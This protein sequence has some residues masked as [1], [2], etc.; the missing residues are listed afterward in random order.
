MSTE[1]ELQVTTPTGEGASQ[2]GD[3]CIVI[4]LYRYLLLT[5][6]LSGLAQ[7]VELNRGHSGNQAIVSY[8]IGHFPRIYIRSSL[9]YNVSFESRRVLYFAS[10][11]F[12]PSS[13]QL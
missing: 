10:L 11:G 3:V 1:P 2:A 12:T 9:R 13:L 5:R 7:R 4:P 8:Q 6:H